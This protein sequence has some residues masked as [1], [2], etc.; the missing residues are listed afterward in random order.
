LDTARFQKTH[1]QRIEAKNLPQEIKLLGM[2]SNLRKPLEEIDRALSII[3]NEWDWHY[4]H[5]SGKQRHAE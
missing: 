2:L 5:P 4:S 3:V 1:H